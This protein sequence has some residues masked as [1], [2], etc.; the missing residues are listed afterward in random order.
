MAHTFC[1]ILM[2]NFVSSLILLTRKFKTSLDYGEN[3]LSK[4][5]LGG[6]ARVTLRKA[7]GKKE[8]V[9]ETKPRSDQSADPSE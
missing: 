6:G 3:P 7:R 9:S 4:K 5:H 2:R 8:A 1:L